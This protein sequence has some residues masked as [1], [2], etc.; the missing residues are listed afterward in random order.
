MGVS[1]DWTAIAM[2][3]EPY[4]HFGKNITTA[5]MFIEQHDTYKPI[6]GG[7]EFTLLY[8]TKVRGFFKLF[9]PMLESTM[10]KELKKSLGNLK[11]VLEA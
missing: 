4:K 5:G 7:T 3:Y 6:E 8:I 1:M 11:R 10:R 2:E 9:T